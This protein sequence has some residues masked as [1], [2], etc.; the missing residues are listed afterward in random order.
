MEM[1]KLETRNA[2][3]ENRKPRSDKRK[4]TTGFRSSL[5]V[6]RLALLVLL[7][8]RAAATTLTGSFK[9]ADGS[10]VASG[11]LLLRL[12]VPAVT[13]TS[14]QQVVNNTVICSIDATGAVSGTCSVQDNANLTPTEY[15]VA[16]LY[17]SN[18]NRLWTQNW[19]ITGASVD[20]GTLQQTTVGISFPNPV[21]QNT[22]AAQAV[23]SAMTFSGNVTFSSPTSAKILNNIRFADQFATGSSTGGIQEAINDLPAA[24]GKVIIP[25]NY[26]ASLTVGVTTGTKAVAIEGHG[27]TSVIS[28]S[29]ITLVTLLSNNS[30]LSN[31]K[32]TDPTGNA[33]TIAVDIN[34]GGTAVTRWRLSKVSIMGTAVRLGTG[35]RTVFGLEGV[36]EACNIELWGTNVSLTASGSLRSNAIE[37]RGNKIREATTG[38]NFNTAGADNAFFFGNTIEGNDTGV[39][40]AP[41]G[42]VTF[43][44]NHFEN[45]TGATPTN[46]SLGT[47]G[48]L[49][50]IGNTFSGGSANRDIII[51]SGNAARHLSVGDQLPNGITHNGSAE[52]IFLQPVGANPKTGTGAVAQILSRSITGT[53]E[54]GNDFLISG[55][56]PLVA[57]AFK[58]ATANPAV[59]GAYRAASSDVFNFRN[60]ANSADVSGLSKDT[61]D[62]VQVGGAAGA[63]TVGPLIV[64]GGQQVSKIL[65]AQA[66]LTFGL[67]AT[68]TCGNQTITVTGAATSNA[69]FASPNYAVEA[70]LS[71]SAFVSAANTVTVRLCNVTASGI[72]PA[73]SSN[74]RVWVVQ[75]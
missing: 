8:Q 55:Y 46:I 71:W 5:F 70:G 67:I 73:A 40:G 38:V 15:Y 66:G 74:W 12:R 50:S 56:G 65:Q 48:S 24:G 13:K 20:V 22:T 9:N 72:T 3:S 47:T 36:I 45:N 57:L 41:A 18:S 53:N 25:P 52:F 63:R 75:E 37:F 44:A 32:V 7:A 31:L 26:T 6:C 19:Y 33:A 39:S 62:V 11:K 17:D 43:V 49:V 1:T 61:S 29:G 58:T 59:T 69:A 64:N 54:G 28:G 27:E 23:Q 16:T 30:T 68:Q 4:P 35:V 51:A 14:P 34:N 2:K 10:A 60:N 42:I 21:V